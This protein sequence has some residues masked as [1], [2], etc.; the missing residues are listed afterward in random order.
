[1]S[2]YYKVL[3]YCRPVFHYR[4]ASK[5]SQM[6]QQGPVLRAKLY[7]N[8]LLLTVGGTTAHGAKPQSDVIVPSGRDFSTPYHLATCCSMEGR[9]V[10]Y[11][12]E[13]HSIAQKEKNSTAPLSYLSSAMVRRPSSSPTV[14]IRP[15]FSSSGTTATLFRCLLSF[16]MTTC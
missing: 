13:Q 11:M 5:L 10:R 3:R 6:L 14:A 7:K 15:V 16:R 12:T 2:R 8:C 9:L 1:V 4:D